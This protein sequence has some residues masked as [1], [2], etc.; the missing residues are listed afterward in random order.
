M[1]N[2]EE[3]HKKLFEISRD[4]VE[5][6][7]ISEFDLA[8]FISEIRERSISYQADGSEDSDDL[9]NLEYDCDKFITGL[10]GHTQVITDV[11]LLDDYQAL[12]ENFLRE[13]EENKKL[14]ENQK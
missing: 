12:Y 9:K 6:Y 8:D 1:I 13:K 5:V 3:A 7:L 2:K 14:R 11:E 10:K 4:F